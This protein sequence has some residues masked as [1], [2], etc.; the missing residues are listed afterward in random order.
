M[1]ARPILAAAALVAAFLM[2]AHAE[3]RTPRGLGHPPGD[4][5]HWYDN[6]C[7]NRRDCEPVEDGAIVR[8]ENGYR[9]RYWASPRPG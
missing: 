3:E 2:A 7:C 8:T 5:L 9:V 4:D 1:T 6:G